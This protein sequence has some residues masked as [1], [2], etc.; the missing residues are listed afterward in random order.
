MKLRI[1]TAIVGLPLVVVVLL[2][3]DKIVLPI[4]LALASAIGEFEMLG[5]IGQR[6]KLEVT[7]PSLIYAAA[8][9]FSARYVVDFSER[10]SYFLA[11]FGV[12]TFIY[13][14]YLMSLAV[15]SKGT[16]TISDMTLTAATALYITV[17]FS[18]M[19]MLRDMN[20]N[21]NDFG[22][23]IFMLIFIGAWIPDGAGYFCGRAFGKHK[24]IPDVSPKKTV[25]GAIG[26]IVFGGLSFV[27]FGAIVGALTALEPRYV[28]LA[29]TGC[30]VAVVSIF[31][32]LIASLIK[33]QYGIKDYGKIF[34]GHGGVMD[35]FDSIIAIAPFLLMI[36]SHPDI[37]KLFS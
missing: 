27:A 26:G 22:F 37:F 5:C 16:K 12:V 8:V 30:V 6:K 31:G 35:R 14:F 2:Y 17:G 28:S 34:P 10:D 24:L 19:V 9:P 32:D 4:V 20:Y 15:L 36:C 33:R 7:V 18:S 3:S 29:V 1:L 13:M 11:V 25:E 21:D 23:Y